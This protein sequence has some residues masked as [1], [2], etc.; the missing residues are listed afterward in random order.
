M[1]LGNCRKRMIALWFS[2]Q[3]SIVAQ[4]RFRVKISSIFNML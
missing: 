3:R 2:L 4:C 1:P